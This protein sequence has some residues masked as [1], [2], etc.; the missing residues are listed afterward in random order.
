LE[1]TIALKVAIR[2]I[3]SHQQLGDSKKSK[4]FDKNAGV[5]ASEERP[6]KWSADLPRIT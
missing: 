4:G 5:L 6:V 1:E 2:Q 3:L